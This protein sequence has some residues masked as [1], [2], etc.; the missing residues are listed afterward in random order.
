MASPLAPGIARAASGYADQ[1]GQAAQQHMNQV[2]GPESQHNSFW[3]KTLNSGESWMASTNQV[4][5]K[6][7]AGAAGMN[8]GQALLTVA[9]PLMGGA[10]M[11]TQGAPSVVPQ[12]RQTVAAPTPD[13]LQNALLTGSMYAGVVGAT[14]MA[15]DMA[16]GAHPFQSPV[17]QQIQSDMGQMF[18]GSP[19]SQRGSFSFN[20]NTVNV[21]AK[22]Y[23]A[24]IGADNPAA[25]MKT[26]EDVATVNYFRDQIRQGVDINQTHG[27]A[28]IEHD[29]NGNVIGADGR[30][31]AMAQMLEQGPDARIPV[32]MNAP[33]PLN[34]L[35]GAND[36]NGQYGRGNIRVPQAM[37]NPQGTQI[38]DAYAAM[39]HDPNHPAVR[40]SYEA[41]KNDINNQWDY[42]TQQLGI[43][44]E[45]WGKEGQPYANSK[46]MMSD[47]TNNRHLHFFQGGDIPADHPLAET[48]P[49]TGLTYNDKFRAVHDLFGHAANGFQFGPGGEEGAYM[50]HAQMMSPES[51]PALTNETRGQNNWVNFG[52]HMRDASGNLIQKGMPGFLAAPDRPFA[53]QK[54]GILPQSVY[55][56]VLPQ[57]PQLT[58]RHWSNQPNLTETDPAFFG[59]GKAGAE[60]ARINDPNFA[61]RTYFGMEGYKEP[62]IQGQR[63]QYS[64]QVDP[65]KYYDIA[66]DPQGFW[67]K[68]YGEGGPT[69]A[70]KAVRDAGFAGYHHNGVLASFDKVPVSPVEQTPVSQTLGAKP[71]FWRTAKSGQT[72]SVNLDLLTGG[73]AERLLAPFGTEAP[74]RNVQP[75]V[76]ENVA[77]NLPQ[78]WQN[79]LKTPVS[80]QNMLD[81]RKG[82]VPPELTLAAAQM[83]Q[84]GYNWY[85]MSR[86]VPHALSDV[87]ALPVTPEMFHG[88]IAATS[89]QNPVV[90]NAAEAFELMHN[91][92]KGGPDVMQTPEDFM[93]FLHSGQA[94]DHQIFLPH[95]GR[96]DMAGA[97]RANIERAMFEQPLSGNKVYSFQGDLK[98]GG[99][100]TIDTISGKGLGAG[101]AIAGISTDAPYLGARARLAEVARTTGQDIHN[102]QSTQWT[103]TKAMNDAPP[104]LMS[105]KPDEVIDYIHSNLAQAPRMDFANVALDAL[106]GKYP[107]AKDYVRV[108]TALRNLLGNDESRINDFK[109]SLRNRIQPFADE[110]ATQPL[111]QPNRRDARAFVRA[112]QKSIPAANAAK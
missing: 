69:G 9:N 13:N 38:A 20:R 22:M 100:G 107:G 54:A 49:V 86:Q 71:G 91:I 27:P 53:E 45:P 81:F 37:P 12:M 46:E 72:G 26:P 87:D 76:P 50:T 7:V 15:G 28:S 25:V 77:K 102:I 43:N 11:A 105:A 51:I 42:A 101:A 40:A 33:Q 16:A 83:G 79:L 70:E 58:L 82:L 96:I 1:M 67:Q 95:G 44:F 14:G 35:Q 110:A 5:A 78:G 73:L 29:A 84:S 62:A 65:S 109:Q 39:T 48:D 32:Q 104:S 18:N 36:F 111:G 47:V 31:R 24:K 89:P 57:Q 6:M 75:I 3:S 8:P 94:S 74:K 97:K 2:M 80:Q 23:L 106:E 34:V 108:N 92:N 21:P 112:A 52:P 90:R 61:P 41:L 66:Q 60:R 59:T 93:N 30:H 68:G 19:A 55:Q 17:V 98:E 103:T 88:A 63:Y 99:Y 4:G 56:D 64:A 85:E 10:V